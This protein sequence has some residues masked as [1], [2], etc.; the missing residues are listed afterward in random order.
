[1][2]NLSEQKSRK[3]TADEVHSVWN[4]VDDLRTDVSSIKSSQ[5]ALIAKFDQVFNMFQQLHGD[6]KTP[7][8]IIISGLG[9]LIVLAI[10]LGGS[11]LAP[12]YQSD[13]HLTVAQGE[14]KQEIA[15]ELAEIKRD[16]ELVDARSQERQLEVRSELKSLDESQLA[17]LNNL[18]VALQREMRLIQ[19]LQ[20]AKR[21]SLAG[22]IE[23]QGVRSSESAD[24]LQALEVR[25]AE[26]IS[27]LESFIEAMT[28][29]SR[30]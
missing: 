29:L 6:R 5:A 1:M 30:N 19:E 10:A 11:A 9:V 20:D 2:T 16:M 21:E 24:R 12:L 7:W 15:T 28:T 4:A 18:D 17:R 27:A 23:S 26:R 3:E 13:S 25:Q 22:K 14:L 8:N